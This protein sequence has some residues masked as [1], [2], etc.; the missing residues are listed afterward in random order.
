[1][2]VL[3]ELPS[4]ATADQPNGCPAWCADHTL[5]AHTAD[6]SYSTGDLEI[7][8]RLYQ[9]ADEPASGDN[10]IQ[11]H[12]DVR[13]DDGFGTYLT[14]DGPL[15]AAAR[16]LA[17]LTGSLADLA[18]ATRVERPYL[19]RDRRELL[20]AIGRGTVR[21]SDGGVEVWRKRGRGQNVNVTRRVRELAAAGWVELGDDER[22]YRLTDTGVR[23]LA[24]AV[25][26]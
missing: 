16:L 4:T 17:A 8:V 22:T 19:S 25:A 3:T 9:A 1:M 11:A 5:D 7:T 12:V 26:R 20:G 18:A 10:P 14:F 13:D 24:A 2:S 23:D 6:R 21:I 15:P